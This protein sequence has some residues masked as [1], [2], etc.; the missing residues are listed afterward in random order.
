M[1]FIPPKTIE[2]KVVQLRRN[3]PGMNLHM[4]LKGMPT[5][6]ARSDTT[7]PRGMAELKKVS[8]R[9]PHHPKPWK[10]GEGGGGQRYFCFFGSVVG[11]F[12]WSCCIHSKT[13]ISSLMGLS[14]RR[15]CTVYFPSRCMCTQYTMSSCVTIVVLLFYFLYNHDPSE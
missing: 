13:A 5:V 7:V 2:R 3:L 11:V 10:G 6:L 12:Y 14:A 8:N 15:L 9:Q 4:F 1:L